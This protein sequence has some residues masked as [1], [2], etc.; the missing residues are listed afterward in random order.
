LF[1]VIFGIV[2]GILLSN[3]SAEVLLSLTLSEAF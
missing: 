3:L 1:I 2:I